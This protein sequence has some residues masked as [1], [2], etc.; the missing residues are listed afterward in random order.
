MA[1]GSS[2][3]S[4]AVTGVTSPASSDL[5]AQFHQPSRAICRRMTKARRSSGFTSGYVSW[6]QG[7][8]NVPKKSSIAPL[9]SQ[10]GDDRRQLKRVNR[11]GDMY[12]KASLEREG[13]VL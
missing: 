2:G 12:V 3:L 4:E 5:L 8:A 10:A 13:S 9:R 6:P 1:L 7:A 11:L